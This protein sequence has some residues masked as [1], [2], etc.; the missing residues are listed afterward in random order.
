MNVSVSKSSDSTYLTSHYWLAGAWIMP[1]LCWSHHW[2]ISQRQALCYWVCMKWM[3][4]EWQK[5]KQTHDMTQNKRRE[6]LHLSDGV[7]KT[8]LVLRLSSWMRVYA[9]HLKSQPN[10]WIKKIDEHFL[11]RRR[12]A[13]F[14]FDF[15]FF[16]VLIAQ[17]FSLILFSF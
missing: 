15:P 13:K 3:A 6:Q 4:L 11:T 8:L 17:Q 12:I 2:V 14:I 10:R 16:F 1:L 9:M 5:P 7:Q